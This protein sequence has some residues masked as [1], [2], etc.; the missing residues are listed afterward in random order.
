MDLLA[1]I[2]A[3]AG[4]KITVGLN[5]SFIVEFL[6]KDISLSLAINNAYKVW[7]N[8]VVEETCYVQRGGGDETRGQGG[9]LV[10]GGGA[11][12]CQQVGTTVGIERAT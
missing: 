10:W 4:P 2:R 12:I 9:L 7:K 8:Y 11:G 1:Q 3:A 5:D 6:A